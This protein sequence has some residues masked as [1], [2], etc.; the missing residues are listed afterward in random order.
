MIVN[1]PSSQGGLNLK[2]S[3]D[4]MDIRYAIQMDNIL[5]D[6]NRDTL[7]NGC[8][9]ISSVSS[10]RLMTY[11]KKGMETLLFAKGGIIYKLNADNSNA[12][13]QSGF[14]SDNW[15]YCSFTDSG[16][17]ISTILTNG[18]TD[19]VQRVYDNSGTLAITSAYNSATS[20]IA[21]CAYKN[22]MY[23][24]VADTLKVKYSDSQAIAGN[25]TELNLGSIFRTGGHIVAIANWTQNASTGMANLICFISNEGE[26]AVYNGLSPEDTDWTLVGVFRIS[27][28]I[29]L[30]CICQLGGDII[31]ITQ[32]GY[33]PL[34]EVLSQDRANKVEISDKIN[35]IVEGK[36]FSKDWG[37]YWYSKKAWLIV[38]APSTDTGFTHEQH[39]LV[40][41]TGGWC[42]FVGWDALSFATLGDN[43]YFCNGTGIYQADIGTTD[44]GK[45]ITYYLQKAYTQLDMPEVKQVLL[46]KERNKTLGQEKIGTRIGVDFKLEDK[47]SHLVQLEGTQTYWDTAIWDV[48]FWSTERPIVQLKT[49]IFSNFG[50]FISVGVLGQSANSLEFYGLQAK[51]KVGTGDTW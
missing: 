3:L 35:P 18:S 12:V 10:S 45:K 19:N 30:N 4:A 46:V 31:V 13:M 23:F 36:D 8:K 29:G 15:Q 44:N 41:N 40:R 20:L 38:N 9:Q 16:G 39:V 11:N 25:L 34:S 51:I 1:I 48:S 27:K 26:I 47:Y 43:L 28:P 33:L 37:V 2:D 14:N 49:P 17:N 42:R 5:P 22:R 6:T 32:D 21:P 50:N 24:A 7:R